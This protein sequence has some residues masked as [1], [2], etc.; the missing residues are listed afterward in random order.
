MPLKNAEE[1]ASFCRMFSNACRV[2]IMRVL[3]NNELSVTDIATKITA[4][5][6]NTSQHLRH[7]KSNGFVR[8]RRDGATIYYSLTSKIDLDNCKLISEKSSG[9][10]K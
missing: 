10:L 5:I 1:Q 4:S 2:R 7:M 3:V 8:S 6:Q 9:N